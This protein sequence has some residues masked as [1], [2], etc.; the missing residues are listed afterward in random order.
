CS[1]VIR[2]KIFS[3]RYRIRNLEREQERATVTIDALWRP[4]LALESWARYREL[5]EMRGRV[6]TL[7]QERSR[8]EQLVSGCR[9]NSTREVLQLPRQCT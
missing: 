3:Q 7:E 1:G 2:N 9:R 4:V 8:R 5:Q 6:P